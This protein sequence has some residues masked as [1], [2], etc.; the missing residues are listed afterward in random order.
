MIKQIKSGEFFK[1]RIHIIS[2]DHPIALEII[3]S[4]SKG[5]FHII[6]S[7]AI[8]GE[9]LET[10]RPVLGKFDNDDS[11]F[12]KVLKFYIDTFKEERIILRDNIID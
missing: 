12:F 4:K 8:I 10:K 11:V 2:I 6:L 9:T 7:D 1:E 3:E 5:F